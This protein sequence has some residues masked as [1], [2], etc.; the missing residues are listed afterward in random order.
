M[1]TKSTDDAA[2]S[3]TISVPEEQ[4]EVLPKAG[5]PLSGDS[6][7]HSQP[8]IHEAKTAVRLS[9]VSTVDEHAQ[10]ELSAREVGQG[11]TRGSHHLDRYGLV[12]R[13]GAKGA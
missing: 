13:P 5:C 1:L 3:V 12:L 9:Q 6:T 7:V 2:W 11:T 4:F 8:S 10:G